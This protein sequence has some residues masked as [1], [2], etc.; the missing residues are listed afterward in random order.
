MEGETPLLQGGNDG[1]EGFYGIDIPL[2]IVEENDFPVPGVGQRAGSAILSGN[3]RHPI[4]TAGTAD[5][6]QIHQIEKL[7]VD[8]DVGGTEEGRGLA[9]DFGNPSGALRDLPA[10]LDRKSVV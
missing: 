5:E 1:F 4:L 9:R 10:D 6:S 2:H 7:L 3:G 8:S